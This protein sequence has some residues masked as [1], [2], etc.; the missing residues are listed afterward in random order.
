MLCVYVYYLNVYCKYVFSIG[1]HHQAY[2]GY[3][4]EHEGQFTYHQHA[5]LRS[6]FVHSSKWQLS[7]Y[8][9]GIVVTR[10]DNSSYY[11]HALLRTPLLILI[12]NDG[13]RVLEVMILRHDL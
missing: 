8:L 10:D 3:Y 11:G 6:L 4:Y 2:Q 5:L 13:I 9:L 12:Y 7:S 1:L